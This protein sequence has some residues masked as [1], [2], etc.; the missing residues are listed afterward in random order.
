MVW[1][2]LYGKLQRYTV[3]FEYVRHLTVSLTDIPSNQKYAWRTGKIL[4]NYHQGHM[5]ITKHRS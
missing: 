2:L 3:Y 5:V 1:Y 4:R